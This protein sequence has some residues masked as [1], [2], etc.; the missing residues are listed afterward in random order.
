MKKFW[1][2]IM[3]MNIIKLYLLTIVLHFVWNF[4][5]GATLYASGVEFSQHVASSSDLMNSFLF[6]ATLVPM[7][8]FIEELMFRWAPMVLFFLGLGILAKNSKIEDEK[9]GKIEKYG[10]ASIVI[11]SSIIFGLVHGN[12]FN[13]LIQGVS[14]VIFSMFYLRTLYRQRQA[15][16]VDK[17]QKMP[18]LSSTL[19]HT[20]SNV[21]LMAL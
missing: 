7:C 9:M 19:Y 1:N 6:T 17:L 12:V 20:M 13:I 3:E 15:G 21:L 14:G 16:K 18:V 11:I 8:A 2:K 10:V 4:T 5:I